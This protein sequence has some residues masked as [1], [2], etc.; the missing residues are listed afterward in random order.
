MRRPCCCCSL[1]DLASP[2]P[3]VGAAVGASSAS[4][5]SIWP[6]LTLA[7]NDDVPSAAASSRLSRRPSPSRKR[8]NQSVATAAVS[9]ST[10]VLLPPSI[11]CHRRR[12]NHQQRAATF[13]AC[14]QHPQPTRKASSASF[15]YVPSSFK[16]TTTAI[17]CGCGEATR[18]GASGKEGDVGDRTRLEDTTSTAPSPSGRPALPLVI[19]TVNV[20]WM[21]G[22][23]CGEGI[24][25]DVGAR[26]R[27]G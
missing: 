17:G 3:L 24:D 16:T 13:S 6:L 4:T 8:R 23:R 15:R 9:S 12:M 14:S 27:R 2:I 7:K 22:G 18:D 19:H 1:A 26:V 5:T 25:G 20:E 10:R 21:L 11:F